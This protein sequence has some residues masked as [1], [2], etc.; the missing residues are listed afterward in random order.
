MAGHIRRRGKRSWELK[1]ECGAD[2]LS[3]KEPLRPDNVSSEWCRLVRVLGLPKATLHAWRHTHASQLIRLNMDVL[4]IS[5]RLG[6]NSPAITLNVYG[7]LFKGSDDRA[8]S[9]ID[10]AFSR[11][12]TK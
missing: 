10:A 1:F 6:H 9:S 2:S 4:T 8:G 3:G 12:L 11:A 5:R 7:H